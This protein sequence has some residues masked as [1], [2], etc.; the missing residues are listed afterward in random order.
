MGP[1]ALVP[2]AGKLVRMAH[3]HRQPVEGRQGLRQRCQFLGTGLH[4]GRAQQQVLGRVAGQRQFGCHQQ[5]RASSMG[6][7]RAVHNAARIAGQ[8]TDRGIELGQ[9]NAD[10]RGGS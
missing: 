6:L 4:E 10:R 9:C 5:G 7:A 8:V 1:C 3:H 2:L